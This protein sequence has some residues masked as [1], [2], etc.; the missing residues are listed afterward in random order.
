MPQSPAAVARGP[1]IT[2]ALGTSFR[3]LRWF[4]RNGIGLAGRDYGPSDSRLPPVVC[5]PG[6]TRNARDFEPVAAHF[7][8]LGRR[9]IVTD[10]RGRGLSQWDPDPRN[11]NARIEMEDVV[12][13]LAGL[14]VPRAALVGTSRGGILAMLM[15]LAAPELIDRTVM[16]DIGPHIELAGLLKIKGY[17][18]RGLG[19]IDWPTAIASL[20]IGQQ[21]QFP[22]LDAAGW[23]RY[24]RRLW[25][26]VGGRPAI[27]YDPA[28]SLGMAGLTPD[29][30][31]PDMWEAFAKLAEKPV[32]VLRGTLSDIL[33]AETVAEMVGRHPTVT[34]VD[35]VDEGHA[36]LLEDAATLQAISRFLDPAN[37]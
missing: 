36:P 35:V 11:Y 9:V 26:D 31:L 32:M 3:P 7:V 29:T 37:G 25:A 4:G 17:V 13:L 10:S 24:A 12:D 6:L 5:L 8:G 16:N 2:D 1:Q 28:L 14:G 34:A 19:Q 23:E 21:T 15:A 30:V 27:D 18:G 33:S 22:R 20:R